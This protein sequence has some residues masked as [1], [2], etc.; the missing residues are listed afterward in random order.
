MQFLFTTNNVPHRQCATELRSLL[1]EQPAAATSVCKSSRGVLCTAPPSAATAFTDLT[2]PERVYGVVVNLPAARLPEPGAED[3]LEQ[4]LALVSSMSDIDWAGPLHAHRLLHPALESPLSFAVDGK[5]RGQRYRQA[6]TSLE[7]GRLVGE[8]LQDRFGWRVDLTK[9][10][11]QVS[12]LLNDESFFVA[13]SLLRRNDSF[14]CRTV[15][16][17][18]AHTSWAMAR[19][20]GDLPSGALVLDPMCGKGALLLETLQLWPTCVAI[21]VDANGQ[22]LTGAATNRAALPEGMAARML[23]LHGDAGALPFADA[24]CAALVCDLP[25]QVTSR[26][27]YSLDTSRGSSLN[28]CVR[29]WARVLRPGAPVVLLNSDS[30]QSRL[31]AALQ[32]PILARESVARPA[33]LESES[34]PEGGDGA[35]LFCI[36][37][38]RPCPLGFTSAVIT[39]ARR[40]PVAGEDAKLDDEVSGCNWGGAGNGSPQVGLRGGLPWEES[41]G[42]RAEWHVLRKAGRSSMV[43]WASQC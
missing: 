42:R 36:Q 14:D 15:G 35:P 24:S 31:R 18:D 26:F 27:G 17:L 21:G 7:L 23:L 29:E 5:R 41:R 19:S 22:Q 13:M 8:R 1:V 20:V 28:G 16:G 40:A 37:C 30:Q 9:P 32:Q 3:F 2:L 11:M 39:V 25:F 12:A 10:A 43:P 6:V 38:E 34:A 33:D 4:L